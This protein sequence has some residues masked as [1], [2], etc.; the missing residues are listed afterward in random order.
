MQ[1]WRMAGRLRQQ[2]KE[3][4]SQE[5]NEGSGGN[6]CTHVSLR[7]C[8]SLNRCGCKDLGFLHFV[9]WL[10]LLKHGVGQVKVSGAV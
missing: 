5:V 7:A 4:L 6:V 3:E 9:F 10:S 2:P 1:M 8:N